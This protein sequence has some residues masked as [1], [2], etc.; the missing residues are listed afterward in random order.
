MQLK[1]HLAISIFV[2]LLFLPYISEDIN[3]IIF[4]F[5]AFIATFI[6]DV[7]IRFSKAGKIPFTG[8]L[9]FFTKHR[10][11]VHSLTLCLIISVIIALFFPILAFGFFTGY[12]THLIADSFT[13]MGIKPF[14]PLKFEV[15]GWITTGS[16]IERGIFYVF[17]ALDLV[18]FTIYLL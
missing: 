15:K 13:K 18:L 17:V 5:T 6:P 4:A 10:G 7:D 11:M 3:K 14:W 16:K 1:T 9:R 12:S 8:I 2:I